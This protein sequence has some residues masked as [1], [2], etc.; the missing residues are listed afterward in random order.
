M[1]RRGTKNM[2]RLLESS[3]HTPAIKLRRLSVLMAIHNSP[4]LSQH[5]IAQMT[6]LSSSMVNNYM[7]KLQQEGFVRVTGKTNR[8]QGYHLTAAGQ[9]ELFSLILEY[10]AENIRWYSAAKTQVAERLLRFHSEG[11][12][13]IALFGAAETAEV[14]HAALKDTPLTVKGIVDSNPSKQG[15]RFNGF[16]VQP[17]ES[18]KEMN[19]DA[20]LITS[21]ARQEE[22]HGCIQQVLGSGM[23]VRKLSDL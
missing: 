11:I 13:S 22:I 17:P 7:K 1:R 5:K 23:Q 6:D 20:V 14:V 8:T 3:F 16:V 15:I 18:L 9:K 4:R 12:R 2:I 10:S 19:A 21:F